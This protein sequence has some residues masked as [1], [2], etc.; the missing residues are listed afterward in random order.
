MICDFIEGDHKEKLN[1]QDLTQ[2][3]T[4]LQKLHKI[5]TRQTPIDLKKSFTSQS[6]ELQKAFRIFGRSGRK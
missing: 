5:Q 3:S 2:L 6:K 1:K 4:L